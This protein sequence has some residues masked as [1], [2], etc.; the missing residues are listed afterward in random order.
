MGSIARHKSLQ[1]QTVL[2]FTQSNL[3]YQQVQK[4]YT[5]HPI[6]YGLEPFF[7]L[8]SI[9]L[10]FTCPISSFRREADE[11]CALLRYYARV[12]VIPYRRF[13]TTHR[14]HLRG[15]RI[16]S[17]QGCRGLPLGLFP[18]FSSFPGNFGVSLIPNFY[19][20]S[21]PPQLRQF[22]HL[23]EGNATVLSLAKTIQRWLQ[24]REQ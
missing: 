6:Y 4:V 13:W 12:V 9:Q 18:I 17:S 21:K 7:L 8:C 15:S 22:Y 19:D 16:R 2:N 23:L 24:I 20:V 10:L 5:E 3:F 1:K 11:N 14:S